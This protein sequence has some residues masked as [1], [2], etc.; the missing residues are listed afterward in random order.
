MNLLKTCHVS[1]EEDVV[2]FLVMVDRVM[3][4]A[5]TDFLKEIAEQLCL[6]ARTERVPYAV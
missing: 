6:V 4:W 5:S 1:L 2:E 3:S